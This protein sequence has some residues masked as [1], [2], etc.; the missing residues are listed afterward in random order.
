MKFLRIK[1]VT[2]ATGLSGRKIYRPELAG[3]FPGRRH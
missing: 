2:R 3:K 1:Q